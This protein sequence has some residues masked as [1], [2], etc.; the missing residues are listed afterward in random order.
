M[1]LRQTTRVGACLRCG[2]ATVMACI[3]CERFL[4]GDCEEAHDESVR[5]GSTPPTPTSP[6]TADR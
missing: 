1:T 5:P 4:C 6:P 3:G 2:V